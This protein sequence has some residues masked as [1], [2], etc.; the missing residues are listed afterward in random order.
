MKLNSTENALLLLRGKNSSA[1]A[2]QCYTIPA[3]PYLVFR[4]ICLWCYVI[5]SSPPCP[6]EC[7]EKNSCGRKYKVLRPLSEG[8]RA[9]CG[10]VAWDTALQ[11]GRSRVRFPMVSLEFLI[12]INLPAAL[13]PWGRIKTLTEMSRLRLKC[14]GT[15][16]ETRFRLSAKRTN[17]F[18]SAGGRQFSR[19]LAAE[20]CASAVVLL[21][22]PCSEVVWRVLAT[23]CIRH[24]P[25]HF[26]LLCVTVC[27]HISTWLY[28]WKRRT[29]K[30]SCALWE[31]SRMQKSLTNHNVTSEN[32]SYLVY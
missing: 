16:A 6:E 8:R 13:W 12:C 27:H 14:V 20:V 17:P 23:H 32:I 28:T 19:L 3:L 15:R 4:T 29:T 21:D 31:A 24:F 25:L 22:T 5:N 7:L 2:L 9:S 11:V 18:K 30:S 10:A 26:P 1:R